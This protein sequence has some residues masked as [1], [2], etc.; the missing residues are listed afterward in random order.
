ME[1]TSGEE[2]FAFIAAAAG[3]GIDDHHMEVG[4]QETE[5]PATKKQ[6]SQPNHSTL[7]QTFPRRN[8]N[9]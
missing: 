5:E 2:L 9:L 4:V 1:T 3:T 6:R 8:W 7:N